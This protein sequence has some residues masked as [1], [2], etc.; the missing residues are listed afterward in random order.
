M[1]GCGSMCPFPCI[2][3][4][5]CSSPPRN[6]FKES[7][8]PLAGMGRSHEVESSQLGG[9]FIQFGKVVMFEMS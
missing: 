6:E 9:L 2:L 1:L 5:L 3:L 4:L 7:V 8:R